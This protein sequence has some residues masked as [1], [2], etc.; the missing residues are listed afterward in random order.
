M[1]LCCFCKIQTKES[2]CP[3][4][5]AIIPQLH[6]H[7]HS[8]KKSHTHYNIP[9][10]ITG[11]TP[12][13]TA[14]ILKK[15]KGPGWF[16]S[17]SM[18]SLNALYTTINNPPPPPNKKSLYYIQQLLDLSLAKDFFKT[19]EDF[20]FCKSIV[21]QYA[22]SLSN[23]QK[24][25][26]NFSDILSEDSF[27]TKLKSTI[28]LTQYI[29]FLPALF[30]LIHTQNCTINLYINNNFKD[31]KFSFKDSTISP[32]IGELY[33]IRSNAAYFDSSIWQIKHILSLKHFPFLT[34]LPENENEEKISTGLHLHITQSELIGLPHSVAKR[35]IFTLDLEECRSL[36]TLPET[37]K[38][39]FT[40]GIIK[41]VN[42]I[43][44]R[45]LEEYRKIFTQTYLELPDS[46]FKDTPPSL[47]TTLPNNIS[48]NL[49]QLFIPC[50]LIILT[51]SKTRY[52]NMKKLAMEKGEFWGAIITIALG[53]SILSS[54]IQTCKRLPTLKPKG[55]NVDTVH[56]MLQKSGIET[57]APHVYLN[58]DN[59]WGSIFKQPITLDRPIVP[60][61]ITHFI[62]SWIHAR[63]S[64]INSPLTADLSKLIKANGGLK[65]AR[66][67]SNLHLADMIKA[68]DRASVD[69]SI[70]QKSLM[71]Y[72]NAIGKDDQRNITLSLNH[73]IH[74]KE[75]HLVMPW[76]SIFSLIQSGY[77]IQLT[78]DWLYLGV[79]HP[80]EFIPTENLA[81]L[82]IKNA[83][84]AEISSQFWLVSHE[85]GFENCQHFYHLPKLPTV[86]P[87]SPLKL[88][89]I[90]CPIRRFPDQILERQFKE[91][92]IINCPNLYFI[93]DEFKDQIE[94]C[95][96][97]TITIKNSGLKCSKDR[98]FNDMSILKEPIFEKCPPEPIIEKNMS[99]VE[100]LSTV[101][102]TIISWV[103]LWF[104][105]TF[106]ESGENSP[107]V[108]SIKTVAT[109]FAYATGPLH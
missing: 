19:H 64:V 99:W 66:G 18:G 31:H 91:L 1:K 25:H 96:L 108:N 32:N 86:M 105:N 26:L 61:C 65:W 3:Q 6:C 94:N 81:T 57:I 11:I 58:W 85:L 83:T 71:E 73:I 33:I 104:L 70:I 28:H 87:R 52:P 13:V 24:Y 95:V 101:K 12:L 27:R 47:S 7:K 88:V 56:T 38:T 75:Y 78:L 29:S 36:T 97:K 43:N 53:T 30:E 93:T 72:K 63:E 103:I 22:A 16:I 106:L 8:M 15:Y 40:Q 100:W 79:K 67:I 35:H 46:L 44:T 41:E 14:A 10:I 50:A 9:N 42:F 109:K 98:Y 74:G 84:L 102:W 45:I 21:Q 37:L 54:K 68:I 92:V 77:K 2:N 4:C 20:V 48:K 107:G 39:Q 49:G 76:D 34:H 17:L 60:K 5:Y 23:D 80:L 62:E 69:Y 82:Y 90:N 59:I 89:F 51:I 55:S